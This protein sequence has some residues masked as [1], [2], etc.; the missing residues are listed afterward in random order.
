MQLWKKIMIPLM[1]FAGVILGAAY[2]SVLHDAVG[3]T[4]RTIYQMSQRVRVVDYGSI[5]IRDPWDSFDIQSDC[6]M[7]V[8]TKDVMQAYKLRDLMTYPGNIGLHKTSIVGDINGDGMDDVILPGVGCTHSEE[9]LSDDSL[10]IFLSRNGAMVYDRYETDCPNMA[11]IRDMDNDDKAEI[12]LM[13]GD[14]FRGKAEWMG[15]VISLDP[16]NGRYHNQSERMEVSVPRDGLKLHFADVDGNGAEEIIWRWNDFN[17]ISY[18]KEG[19]KRSKE[20]AMDVMAIAPWKKDELFD[21]YGYTC[22]KISNPDD[23]E[24]VRNSSE[25]RIYFPD[26]SNSDFVH[27]DSFIWWYDTSHPS[28]FDIEMCRAGVSV[29]DYIQ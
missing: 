27:R 9:Y 17:V 21:K 6:C 24:T 28:P 13:R 20:M 29:M 4:G 12:V 1:V 15:E 2:P 3:N 26:S 10:Y 5:G 7:L 23:A 16:S 14:P 18:G 25:V 11:I 19:S 8:N 22:R